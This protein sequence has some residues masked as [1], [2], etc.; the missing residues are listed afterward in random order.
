MTTNEDTI[1]RIIKAQPG[2]TAYDI[3]DRLDINEPAP[4][5]LEKTFVPL[6]SLREDGRISRRW[7]G[8]KYVYY[9]YS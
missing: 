7:Q 5:T 6:R 2:L 9:P 8:N 4:S 1:L 3:R